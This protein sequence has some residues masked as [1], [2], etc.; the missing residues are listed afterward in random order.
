MHLVSILLFVRHKQWRR[1]INNLKYY[2]NYFVFAYNI[3]LSVIFILEYNK[4]LIIIIRLKKTIYRY[5]LQ[6]DALPNIYL[7][8][9]S[10]RTIYL[11]YKNVL[12]III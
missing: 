2:I 12:F 7:S 9:S 1:E 3:S 8:N 4:M 5:K 10:G 6:V 11:L